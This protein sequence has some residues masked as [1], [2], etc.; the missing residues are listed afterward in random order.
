MDRATKEL[1]FNKPANKIPATL[2]FINNLWYIAQVGKYIGEHPVAHACKK[3]TAQIHWL[4][5]MV[6]KQTVM[7]LKFEW[8]G[9]FY[10]LGI[11]RDF[12]V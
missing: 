2:G 4:L 5:G 12:M 10:W 8:K 3:D 6:H 11:W 7:A 1:F 9:G